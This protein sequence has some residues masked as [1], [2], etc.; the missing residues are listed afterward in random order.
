[1]S[2]S[3]DF[4]FRYRTAAGAERA[5]RAQDEPLRILVMGDFSG[6]RDAG[7]EPDLTARPAPEVDI[8]SL[9]NLPSRL[10]PSLDLSLGGRPDDAVRLEFAS[11]DDFHP[12]TLFQKLDLF[13]P[14]RRMRER[15]LDPAS[16]AEAAAELKRGTQGPT[17]D[18]TAESTPPSPAADAGPGEEDQ[19]SML[20]RLLGSPAAPAAT[21]STAPAAGVPGSAAT[22]AEALIR[23]L[24]EPHIVAEANPQQ[25]Q[26]VSIVDDGLSRQL[27][28][29]LHHPDFQALEAA[30]RALNW[31]VSEVE[32]GEDLHLHV[33]DVARS[34][35]AADLDAAGDELTASGLYR[36]LVERGRE[37]Y[38]GQGW[39]L[40]VGTYEFGAATADL[41]LLAG[42]GAIASH[43]GGPLVAAADP[44][45]LGCRSLAETPDPA[46]WPGLDPEAEQRW[47]ALRGA[48]VARW[49]GLI[50]PRVLLRLPYG[51]ETDPIDGF[52]FEE[53]APR[54]HDTYLWG[55]PAF[56]AA[57]LIA[58]GFVERG[59]AAAPGDR[60][61]VG[62]LPA[63]SYKEDGEARLQAG[64]ELYPSERAAEAILGRGLM[65]LVSLRNRNAARLLRF[66]SLADPPAALAGPWE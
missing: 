30:W 39:S 19:G 15:L 54:R 29:V 27:R 46:D 44:A 50:L 55:N 32:T 21:P 1:M 13:A 6:R 8:D 66:Q 33:M 5:A 60:L 48:A 20:E 49:I 31:L 4:E 65:P 23:R 51:S 62:N 59:G 36:A 3:I 24:V 64:A 28:E 43:A 25:A 63:H 53:M 16:F 57:L 7:A 38:G 14:L 22:T 52:A 58:Q 34:E 35:L 26:L 56:A 42:L 12:D 41:A 37:S 2:A 47:Q 40:I 61:D 18:T 45:L 10:A 9:E 11:L 17:G